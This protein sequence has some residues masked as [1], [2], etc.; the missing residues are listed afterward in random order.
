MKVGRNHHLLAI[1]LFLGALAAGGSG[2]P[3]HGE[4][5]D[6][7][8]NTGP[9]VCKDVAKI[10][11]VKALQQEINAVWTQFA[12][13]KQAAKN[14]ANACDQFVGSEQGSGRENFVS[15]QQTMSAE[16]E[17]L[18][19]AVKKMKE[20]AMPTWEAMGSLGHKS[21]VENVRKVLQVSAQ[22][23]ADIGVQVSQAC[24]A[25]T[26][27]E[28]ARAQSHRMVTGDDLG[29]NRDPR[30]V[31]EV[32]L[33][34][35]S[36]RAYSAELNNEAN[37]WGKQHGLNAGRPPCGE[38]CSSILAAKAAYEN[39]GADSPQYQRALAAAQAAQLGRFGRSKL[40][41]SR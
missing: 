5:K 41:R 38:K 23:H 37:D 10:P 24:N 7:S 39:Y 14:L 26:K 18:K 9:K 11:G 2:S 16:D 36:D 17:K 30:K 13:T 15:A 19:A 28:R 22:T 8:S 1:P 21:C 31:E 20:S 35:N 27:S 25:G 3:A 33:N 6:S 34:P 29:G 12:P 40:T 4:D 32:L